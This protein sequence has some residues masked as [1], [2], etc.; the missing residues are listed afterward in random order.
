[1]HDNVYYL[2]NIM[3][4]RDFPRQSAKLAI[5]SRTPKDGS[6]TF[7]EELKY[8]PLKII[9]PVSKVNSE[10]NIQ[11]LLYTTIP[12]YL[13]KDAFYRLWIS[14]MAQISEMFCDINESD[15]I[16]FC[17]TSQKR[18]ALAIMLIMYRCDYS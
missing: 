18:I 12:D 6:E 3:Y 9:G 10:Q 15:T 14:D 2:P 7:F 13:R 8:V 11:D 17:L 1:M 5:V 4:L 16:G